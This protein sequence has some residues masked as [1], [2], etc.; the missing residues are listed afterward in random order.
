[1]VMRDFFGVLNTHIKRGILS[2]VFLACTALCCFLMMFFIN[3][4]YPES[5]DNSLGLYYFLHRAENSG[6]V[7][8][9]MMIAAFPATMLFYDDWK[10]GSIKFIVPR[11]GCKK[12]TFAVTFAA[13]VTAG[14]VM[15]L[16]LTVFS[17]YVLAKCPA[18]PDLEPTALRVYTLGFPNSGLLC[19]GNAL[20][21]YLLY[22]LT[23]GAMAAFFAVTA[24]LQSMIV[25]NKPLTVISPVLVYILYFSFNLFYILPAL[26]NPFVLFRNGYKLYLVFGGTEDGSLFSP[27]A[28]IYPVL[29]CIVFTVIVS[30][31]E[32]KL[33]RSKMNK[34]I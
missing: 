34:N 1:M 14:A 21:C 4:V 13:A 33:L 11:I 28:A 2:P 3:S 22:F 25:T 17:M 15:F 30:L 16:S 26:L 23:K 18:I 7:Y 24:V 27:A 6:S 9:I 29:F 32:I 19:T 8:M 31:I 20:L 5:Y 10:S 12:Y